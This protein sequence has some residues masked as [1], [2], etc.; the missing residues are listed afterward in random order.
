[1]QT[2]NIAITASSWTQIADSTQDFIL[3]GAARKLVEVALTN[4]N[5]APTGLS[6]HALLLG[7]GNEALNRG[8]VGT[9]FV[10]ARLP[11]ADPTAGAFLVVTK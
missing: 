8:S 7:P 9:G 4:A 3:S 11:L 1:M 6:G 5:A 2:S 10:W